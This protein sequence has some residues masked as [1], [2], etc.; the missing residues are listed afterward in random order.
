MAVKFIRL[1]AENALTYRELDVPL[2]NQGLVLITG[3]NRDTPG[4]NGSGKSSIWEILCHLLFGTTGKGLSKKGLVNQFVGKNMLVEL[5]LEIDGTPYLFREVRKHDDHGTGFTIFE[6]GL[7][8]TPKRSS[9]K[10]EPQLLMQELMR[11]N[12]Q[13]YLGLVYLCQHFHHVLV[14]GTRGE[15]Q[16]YLSSLF[17]L[18]KYDVLCKETKTRAKEVDQQMAGFQSYERDLERCS[19]ALAELPEAALLQAFL[20]TSATELEE[21]KKRRQ[22][23]TDEIT[24]LRAANQQAQRKTEALEGLD[25][26]GFP[27]MSE[28]EFEIQRKEAETKLSKTR[29]TVQSLERMIQEL[30]HRQA[31][32]EQI[33][34]EPEHPQEDLQQ[35]AARLRASIPDRKLLLSKVQERDKLSRTID[36]YLQPLQATAYSDDLE[37][38]R[39]QLI[40]ASKEAENA[41]YTLRAAKDALTS[42]EAITGSTCPTCHR[43]IS[44]EEKQTLINGLDLANKEAAHATAIDQRAELVGVVG[45]LEDVHRLRDQVAGL[46]DD[47]ANEAR[48]LLEQEEVSLQDTEAQLTV[49]NTI[50]TLTAQ[51]QNLPQGN[52]EV[53]EAALSDF[54]TQRDEQKAALDRYNR[55]AVLIRDA[56]LGPDTEV[57][58]D[59]ELGAKQEELKKVAA[60]IDH[61]IEERTSTTARLAE[62]TELEHQKVLA[63]E[64][65]KEGEALRPRQIYLPHLAEAFGP[66]GL[67]TSR[68]ETIMGQL[69][70][71]LPHFLG[72]LFAGSGYQVSVARDVE[73]ELTTKHGGTAITIPG[74]GT[75]GGE[76]KAL[77]MAML[78]A[79]RT[80]R[81]SSKSANILIVDEPYG[82]LDAGKRGVLTELFQQLKTTEV[83]GSVFVITHEAEVLQHSFDKVWTVVRESNESTLKV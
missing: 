79:L 16:A 1:H 49:W 46:P 68:L 21:C 81:T 10:N 18:D 70:K 47:D 39:T 25:A 6:N 50:E 2:D 69:V 30:R 73:L 55:A 48:I 60:T 27:V 12:L 37:A 45:L 33:P 29:Q 32:E 41:E 42:L 19:E 72:P 65:L 38:V 15:K 74:K 8:I 35:E 22:T 52:I 43:P 36:A 44:E 64:K 78:F 5:H 11:F 13:E 61:L 63:E 20:E 34:E 14:Q 56:N 58:G 28:E 59:T 83:V 77:D 3:E 24:K 40:S 71:V 26:L 53:N 54:V 66:K 82:D 23:L 80:L 31:I 67:K 51:L 4:S 57:T 7:D 17:G 75:S 62:R 76:R 9:G